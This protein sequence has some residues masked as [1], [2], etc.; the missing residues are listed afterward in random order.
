MTSTSSSSDEPAAVAAV[1]AAG[2]VAPPPALAAA[3]AASAAAAATA[4]AATAAAA[5][6][7]VVS[8]AAA[9]A[10]RSVKYATMAARRTAPGSMYRYPATAA[11]YTATV[12]L[13]ACGGPATKMRG[14]ADRASLA[15]A[16]RSPSGSSTSRSSPRAATSVGA[17]SSTS[18]EGGGASPPLDADACGARYRLSWRTAGVG[19]QAGVGGSGAPT[20]A[21]D[22]LDGGRQVVA[23]RQPGTAALA[24]CRMAS[25]DS[26]WCSGAPVGLHGSSGACCTPPAAAHAA[27]TPSA[28]SYAGAACGVANS[29]VASAAAASGV[30]VV[31]GT[32]ASS[33]CRAAPTKAGNEQHVAGMPKKRCQS[34]N[35]YS[36]ASAGE[37]PGTRRTASAPSH[38]CHASAGSS[39]CSVRGS[40]GVVFGCWAGGGD[41]SG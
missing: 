9:A 31:A 11:R 26:G 24:R 41:T 22:A 23:A 28:A 27:S 34:F 18:V 37:V 32:Q 7:T 38:A 12:V 39:F 10:A 4:A 15:K 36:A 21:A 3:A 5:R 40:C 33:S 17:A 8:L 1:T 16:N 25:S 20:A 30:V 6:R 2:S 29:T 19:S 35:A 14:G 13:P